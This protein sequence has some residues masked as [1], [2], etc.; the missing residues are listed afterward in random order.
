MAYTTIPAGSGGGGGGVTSAVAGTGVAVS[1]ATGAVTFSLAAIADQKILG[2]GS[3]SSAAPVGLTISASTSQ[4]VATATTLAST[5][6]AGVAGGQTITGGTLTTQSLTVHPNAA[7]TT[8]GRLVVTG[9]GI[10]LSANAGSSTAP[11]IVMKGGSNYGVYS[12]GG[13]VALVSAGFVGIQ[14]QNSAKVLLPLGF[15]LN[16]GNSIGWQ[17]SGTSSC[18]FSAYMLYSATNV[19]PT[20]HDGT[21][22]EHNMTPPTQVSASG[23]KLDSVKFAGITATFT[24]GVA[25]TTAAGLNHIDVEPPTF[26]SSTAT[27]VTNASTV[28]IKNAPTAGGSL[29]IANSYAFWVQAGATRLDGALSITGASVANGA[30]TLLIGSTG[31]AGIGTISSAHAYL[32]FKDSGG[33]TS[34]IPYWQ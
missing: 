12:D 30:Q 24:G 22:W 2:N 11:N 18:L 29:T 8:T 32:T 13:S 5:L 4:L 26:T 31:P 1:G 20:A 14:V 23:T 27:A 25:I 33:T 17:N 15:F 3:G 21:T 10:D 16:A 9:L 7:D 28:T 6:V 34:Y 19:T